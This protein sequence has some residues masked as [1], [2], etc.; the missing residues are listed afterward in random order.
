MIHSIKLNFMENTYVTSL[1][2]IGTFTVIHKRGMVE[3]V[4]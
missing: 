1:N 4:Y 3:I 2:I